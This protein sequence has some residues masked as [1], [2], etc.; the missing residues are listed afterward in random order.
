[1]DEAPLDPLDD[2]IRQNPVF[3]DVLERN[4]SVTGP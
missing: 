2:P 3:Q 4:G 1:M